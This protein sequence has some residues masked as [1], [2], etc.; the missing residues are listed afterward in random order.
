MYKLPW[1]DLLQIQLHTWKI[2]CTYKELIVR[3]IF[4]VDIDLIAYLEC[5]S[6]WKFRQLDRKIN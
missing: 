6:M 4:C 5:K 2:L 3:G 1:N